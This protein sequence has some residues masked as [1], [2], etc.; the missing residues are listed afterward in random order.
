VGRAGEASLCAGDEEGLRAQQGNEA[1]FLCV[2]TLCGHF[3]VV[4]L[5]DH[6]VWSLCVVTGSYWPMHSHLCHV[7]SAELGW[8][9]GRWGGGCMRQTPRTTGCAG[10]VTKLTVC[11]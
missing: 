6:F 7:R 3:G 1:C 2:G 9:G 10:S 11:F 5:Y 4:T 8:Q